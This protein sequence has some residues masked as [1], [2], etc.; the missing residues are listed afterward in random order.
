MKCF[1][2]YCWELKVDWYSKLAKILKASLSSDSIKG[3][4]SRSCFS[5]LTIASSLLQSK[6]GCNFLGAH[7]CNSCVFPEECSYPLGRH[8]S[9]VNEQWLLHGNGTSLLNSKSFGRRRRLFYPLHSSLRTRRALTFDLWCRPDWG[10]E[11]RFLIYWALFHR[12]SQWA[13]FLPVNGCPLACRLSVWDNIW[14]S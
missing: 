14:S 12:R 1:S 4:K 11:F 8:S 6:T 13:A 3:I 2:T 9:Q 5:P 7:S 10:R